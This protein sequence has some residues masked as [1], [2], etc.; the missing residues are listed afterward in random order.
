MNLHIRHK[1]RGW[2]LS[3]VAMRRVTLRICDECGKT[4][5]KGKAVKVGV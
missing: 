5:V 1:W 2:T 4:K 3:P